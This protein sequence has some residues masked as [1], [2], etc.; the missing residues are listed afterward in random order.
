[1]LRIYITPPPAITSED[2]DISSP[3]SDG[4]TPGAPPPRAAAPPGQFF[5]ELLDPRLFGQ[6]APPPSAPPGKFFQE[7]LDPRRFGQ[8]APPP[9]TPPGRFLPSIGV[10]L[11]PVIPPAPQRPAPAPVPAVP[12]A[13]TPVQ[14]EGDGLARNAA[15]GLS[16]GV[17][18]TLGFPVDAATWLVNR[19]IDGVNAVAGS[20]ISNLGDLPLG[21][22]SIATNLEH[23]AGIPDPA[24]VRAVTLA[25]KAARAAGEGAAYAIAPQALLRAGAVVA[26]TR[27]PGLLKTVFGNSNTLRALGG[28]AVAGGIGGGGGTLAGEA[29]P[30]PLK[31]LAE[32]GGNLAGGGIVAAAEDLPRLLAQGGRAVRDFA[33]P[34]IGGAMDQ[35]PRPAVATVGGMPAPGSF[36]GYENRMA[37]PQRPPLASA[38]PE[39][40]HGWSNAEIFAAP[41]AATA[42]FRTDYHEVVPSA[43]GVEVLRQESGRGYSAPRTPGFGTHASMDELMRTGALP[44]KAGVILTDD[45]I[46]FGD[47]YKL[48]TLNGRRVE[49]VIVRHRLDGRPVT[50]LYSGDFRA[51]PLP[52]EGWIVAHTHPTEGPTQRWPSDIDMRIVNRRFFRELEANPRARPAPSWIIWGPGPSDNTRY[53]PGFGKEP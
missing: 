51:C 27:L 53:F 23:Y 3:P 38:V 9:P 17:Y 25:E 47:V 42:R 45:R 13:Q 30:E 1:M 10:H 6:F 26:G 40:Q 12:S 7:L 50:T 28:E 18:G 22:R 34:L 5:Q 32:F 11:P 36:E 33:A 16:E 37:P 52:N 19:G 39:T 20:E 46:Q 21:S 8:N 31:P 41:D 15:A 2:G 44:G 43:G 48:S 14:Q 4:D 35:F 29:A 49:F 24:K